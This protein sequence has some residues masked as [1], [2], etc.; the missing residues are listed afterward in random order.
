MAIPLFSL[1]LRHSIIP[2]LVTMGKYDGSHHCLTAATSEN[3]ASLLNVYNI[4]TRGQ[5]KICIFYNKYDT[6]FYC[7]QSTQLV[8]D[9]I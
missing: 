2:H 1:Q 9:S 3:K 8:L 4:Y 5:M 7:V 6:Y